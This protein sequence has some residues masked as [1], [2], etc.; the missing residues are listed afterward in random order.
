[1]IGYREWNI[2][3]NPEV[4]QFRLGGV[5]G[6]PTV[7]EREM[8]AV[9][10]EGRLEEH[11]RN[12]EHECGLY[13]FKYPE[14]LPSRSAGG[15]VVGSVYNYGII[16]QFS[17]GF[18][19]SHAVIDV[20]FSLPYICYQTVYPIHVAKECDRPVEFFGIRK[21]YYYLRGYRGYVGY[22][23]GHLINFYPLVCYCLEHMEEVKPH[24]KEVIPVEA[25]LREI[26]N[27]YGVPVRRWEEL[28]KWT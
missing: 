8:A 11:L 9:C 10:D 18:R 23:R 14:S 25:A 13:S 15:A 5:G 28:W 24:L 4:K 20:L 7:W 17:D 1:M 19:S 12:F 6:L 26:S 16:A 21:L 27:Y 22:Y 2:L 3:Y